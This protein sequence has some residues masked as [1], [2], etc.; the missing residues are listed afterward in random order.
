MRF[1]SYFAASSLLAVAVACGSD[2]SGPAIGP[3]S[4]VTVATAPT[5]T[6]A[7]TTSVGNFSVKVADANGNGVAG[8]VVSFSSTG[9]GGATFAPISATTDGSGIATT[10]VTLGS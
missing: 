1:S 5:A 4:V 8:S 2:A 3:A 7:V 9:V 6:G 10:A